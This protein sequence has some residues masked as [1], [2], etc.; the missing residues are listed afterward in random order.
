MNPNKSISANSKGI[1]I[2]FGDV[3][4]HKFVYYNNNNDVVKK[5]Q[6]YGT[7]KYQKIEDTEFNKIQKR[8]YTEAVYGLK[9]I[10]NEVLM[11]MHTKVI[12]NIQNIHTRAKNVINNYKQEISNN[13]IDTFLSKLFPKSPIIK[14]MLNVK[15]VDPMIKVPMSLKDLKIS[16]HMLAQKLVE[17]KVLPEN[18]FNLL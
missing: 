9:A 15:G 3:N 5:I 16:K 7:T 1:I 10:P 8:L 11:V 2:N 4:K 18:F 17:F 13:N 14:Q 12:R 6:L